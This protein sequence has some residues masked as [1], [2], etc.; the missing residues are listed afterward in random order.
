MFSDSGTECM[1]AG[2]TTSAA[3]VDLAWSGGGASLNDLRS[4]SY[5]NSLSLCSRGGSGPEFARSRFHCAR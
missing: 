5:V 2:Y 4:S 1:L 3:R